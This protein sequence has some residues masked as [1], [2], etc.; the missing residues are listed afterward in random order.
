MAQKTCDLGHTH[1]VCDRCGSSGMPR[2]DDDDVRPRLPLEKVRLDLA[3][4]GL[5]AEAI[6]CDPCMY[7]LCDLMRRWMGR[8]VADAPAERA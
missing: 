5:L 6:V 8:D 4:G 3:N 7:A 2:E 1:V